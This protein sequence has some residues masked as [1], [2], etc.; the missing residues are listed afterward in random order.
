M[1]EDRKAGLRDKGWRGD[2]LGVGR[3]GGGMAR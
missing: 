1:L 2:V 3:I